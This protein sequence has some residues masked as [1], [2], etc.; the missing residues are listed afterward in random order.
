MNSWLLKC[1]LAFPNRISKS[2][3]PLSPSLLARSRSLRLSPRNMMI[4]LLLKTM[5]TLTLRHREELKL[6]VFFAGPPVSSEQ[7][8]LQGQLGPGEI[9]GLRNPSLVVSPHLQQW[10]PG[11]WQLTTA[12]PTHHRPGPRAAGHADSF[13]RDCSGS[14]PLLGLMTA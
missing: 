8:A 4:L 9:W 2:H 14:T 12:P 5:N 3:F 6:L 7:Q 10:L 1:F 13:I 11:P